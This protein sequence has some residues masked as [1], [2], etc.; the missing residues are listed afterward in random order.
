MTA[1]APQEAETGRS[2]ALVH[3]TTCHDVDTA[4]CGIDLSDRSAPVWGPLSA[5]ECIVCADLA[6]SLAHECPIAC[7]WCEDGCECGC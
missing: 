6:E 4:L 1:P 3:L 2:N 5:A 7:I